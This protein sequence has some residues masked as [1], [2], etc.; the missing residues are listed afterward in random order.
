ML[1]EKGI[2]SQGEKKM[3][4]ITLYGRKK[5]ANVIVGQALVDDDDY[6][7]LKL[8]K[9][10]LKD[11]DYAYRVEPYSGIGCRPIFVFMHR[12]ILKNR[13]HDIKGYV[14]DHKDGN[15]LNNQKANL[16][17]C[18][19][20]QNNQNKKHRPTKNSPYKGVK[21]LKK[22]NKYQAS[23]LLDLGMYSTAEKAR[24]EYNEMA[25]GIYGEFANS[26]LEDVDYPINPLSGKQ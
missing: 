22:V 13:G 15:R 7:Y 17:K 18:T 25:K 1:I 24:D 23:I 19:P 8:W 16:R 6:D 2:Y 4:N 20:L 5:K 10:H 14:V 12:A 9:W 21:Y 11:D 26:G 3:K